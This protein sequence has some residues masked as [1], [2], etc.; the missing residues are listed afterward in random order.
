MREPVAEVEQSVDVRAAEGVDGLVRVADHDQVAP[1]T[2]Q[3][4]QQSLLAGVGVLV[5]V[6]DHEVELRA[7]RLSTLRCLGVEDRAVH[8]LG[9]VQR[10]QVVEHREV[11]VK[12]ACGP[13]P[14][15]PSRR[16]GQPLEVDRIEAI[17]ADASEQRPDLVGEATGGECDPELGRPVVGAFGEVAG[18]QVAH[19]DV[20]LGAGEE[21]QGPPGVLGQPGLSDE[22]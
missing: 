7:E 19:H 16:D 4:L 6:H 12:E 13:G 17:A 11:G 15:R 9:V 14:V 20:L 5:L 10:R 2:G 8:E 3:C 18:Q 21:A 1:V 22:R